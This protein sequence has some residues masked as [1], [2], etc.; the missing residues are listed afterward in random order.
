[1]NHTHTHPSSYL[2]LISCCL[3]VQVVVCAD[4]AAAAVASCSRLPF[5]IATHLSRSR[6]PS[7][8]HSLSLYGSLS[9]SISLGVRLPCVLQL[10]PKAEAV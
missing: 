5:I 3:A 6:F 7:L 2:L 8:P 1:M 4:P 10:F 9:L